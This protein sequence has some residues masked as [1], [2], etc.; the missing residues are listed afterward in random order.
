MFQKWLIDRSIYLS[1][2]LIL[3]TDY[4]HLS[5]RNLHGV[6]DPSCALLGIAL[7]SSE[8]IHSSSRHA[9]AYVQAS[10]TNIKLLCRS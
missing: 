3:E 10:N 9:L 4:P 8:V 2:R 7:Y 6:Y 5:P 1:D